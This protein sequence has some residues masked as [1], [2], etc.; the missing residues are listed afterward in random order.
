V[1]RHGTVMYYNKWASGHL[2]RKPEYID[3]DV[4]K[5]HRQAVT[6]PRFDAMLQLFEEDRVEPVRYVARP[7]GKTTILVTVSPIR[8]D[9]EL[10]GFSQSLPT[11]ALMRPAGLVGCQ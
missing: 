6:N 11:K 8:V 3:N 4:R 2:D 9:G 7:Y 5:R 10:V 1:D